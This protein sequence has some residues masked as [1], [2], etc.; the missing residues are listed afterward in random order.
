[1]GSVFSP[2][3]SKAQL[4]LRAYIRRCCVP[5]ELRQR[6]KRGVRAALRRS[7]VPAT[8]DGLRAFLRDVTGAFQQ[9]LDAESDILRRCLHGK[10]G[11]LGSLAALSEFLGVRADR[12]AA[13]VQKTDANGKTDSSLL[14]ETLQYE[15]E[16]G[17]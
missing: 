10:Y 17:A 14:R 12:G 7:G 15:A 11:Q 13:F 2:V 9:S 5:S 1:M 16:A 8:D 6:L 4:P 3:A